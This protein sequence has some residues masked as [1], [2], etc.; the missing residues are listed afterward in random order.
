MP[1]ET[2][3]SDYKKLREL[4]AQYAPASKKHLPILS[5]EWGYASHNQGVSLETQAAYAVRQQLNNLYSG[6]PLSIWY[7][8]KNDGPDPANNEHNFG[9]M[10][11]DLKP[12]PAYIAL[13]NM[14]RELKG[15]KFQRRLDLPHRDEYALIFKSPSGDR[16]IAAWTTGASHDVQ[17]TNPVVKLHLDPTPHFI[18]VN[19]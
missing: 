7:D 2:T 6:V 10:D 16:K 5:G 4:I 19:K 15:Y 17:A 8:W 9:L 11:Q 3:G 13:Q 18:Q 12:K 14:I 1:P